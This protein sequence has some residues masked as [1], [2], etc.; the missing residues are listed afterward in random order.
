MAPQ[1]GRAERG[2]E[3]KAARGEWTGGIPPFGY[4]KARGE[5]ALSPDPASAPIVEAIF[6][7]YVEERA[8]ARAIA[9]WL[10][11][12]GQRTRTGGR[13]G[14]SGVLAV[15]RNRAYIGE[16]SF[17]GVW[18]PGGQ[19]PLVER[20]LFDAAAAIL[21]ERASSAS[22]RRT[23][24]T[25]YLLSGLPFVCDRCGHP[26]IGASARGRAGRRYA[27]YTCSTRAHRGSAGCTQ[28]RLAKDE[29][30]FAVLAQMRDVYADTSLVAA[31]L[32]E[33]QARE[34]VRHAEG[35]RARTALE[36]QAADVRRKIERYVSAFE[37]GELSGSRL[38]AWLDELEGPSGR[39]RD[40]TRRARPSR[41]P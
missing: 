22:L 21:D 30:E 28:D 35:E 40:P 15:L 5:S 33:A 41:D 19:P 36:A 7:R 3:R 12:Q 25:D 39:P 6:R 23:N 4:R 14:T 29:L 38:G 37:S 32:G 8:G 16:V 31:A 2:W 13:W 26:M 24:P 9:A 1:A 20:T 27:Y 34:A 11:G 17:R 18:R 10:D